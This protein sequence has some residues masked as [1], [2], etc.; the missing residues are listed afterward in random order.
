MIEEPL[1]P[2]SRVARKGHK[3]HI[4][5]GNVGMSFFNSHN[6]DRWG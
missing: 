5:S 6:V 3:T 1:Y 2:E 4:V